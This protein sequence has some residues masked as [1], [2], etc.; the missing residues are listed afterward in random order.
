MGCI[1]FIPQ[2]IDP[3]YVKP[4]TFFPAVDDILCYFI[5]NA[6]IVA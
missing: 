6:G 5:V 3:D 4:Y 1:F 2:R